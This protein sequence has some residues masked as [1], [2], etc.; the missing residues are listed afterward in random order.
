MTLAMC[1]GGPAAGSSY[2]TT[3]RDLL[4]V[5]IAWEPLRLDVCDPQ[6]PTA[7]G[8]FAYRIVRIRVD[9]FEHTFWIP[10]STPV[11]GEAAYVIGSLV[12]GYR[13]PGAR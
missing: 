11:E 5:A 10:R 3:V 7:P 1:I 12:G 4:I 2:E 8:S 9:G 6:N 13:A